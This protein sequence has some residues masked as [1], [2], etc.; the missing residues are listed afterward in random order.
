MM[1]F[2][3]RGNLLLL[4]LHRPHHLLQ[5]PLQVDHSLA[6]VESYR[7]VRRV[8][9]SV[10]QIVFYNLRTF[11]SSN[12]LFI[13]LS[14]WFV[15]LSLRQFVRPDAQSSNG[16]SVFQFVSPFL[17]WVPSPAEPKA[18][19]SSPHLQRVGWETKEERHIPFSF[20]CL[21]IDIRCKMFPTSKE[22]WAL[23]SRLEINI[24]F[25]T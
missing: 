21:C 8:L 10:I 4:P 15:C 7:N 2:D 18:L 17:S 5:L 14:C 16:L 13:S 9:L 12:C 19:D 22:I 11:R 23:S 24:F 3:S 1:Q 6:I 20:W 25:Q